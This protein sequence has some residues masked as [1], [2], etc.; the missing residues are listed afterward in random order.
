[1]NSYVNKVQDVLKCSPEY[2]EMVLQ[3]MAEVDFSEISLFMF[4][5]E[6]LI[7]DHILNFRKSK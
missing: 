5:V 2:A 1:M 4:R 3:E 6:V 7:A